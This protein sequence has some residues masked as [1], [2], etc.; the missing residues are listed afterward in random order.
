MASGELVDRLDRIADLDVR[1]NTI[2]QALSRARQKTTKTKK[3]TKAKKN[4]QGPS[5]H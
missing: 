2:S 1:A 3:T 4:R 5:E